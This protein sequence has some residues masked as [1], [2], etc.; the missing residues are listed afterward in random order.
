VVLPVPA[1][2]TTNTKP[3]VPATARAASSW[4]TDNPPASIAGSMA[5]ASDVGGEWCAS[6]QT[7]TCSSSARIAGVVNARSVA[8]S[9]IGRP[10]RRNNTPGGIGAD[11][12]TQSRTITSPAT[13]SSQAT[14]R[15]GGTPMS[16]GTAA[17]SSRSSSAGR[18]VDCLDV[19]DAIASLTMR[20][21]S[22][23]SS[24]SRDATRCVAALTSC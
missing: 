8:A 5:I 24:R 17:A 10:S 13:S 19:N 16:V 12:S 4:G 22:R 14:N 20:D 2:P 23:C 18:H 1:A 6:A 21:T 3:R 9:L 15:C 7:M 11:N